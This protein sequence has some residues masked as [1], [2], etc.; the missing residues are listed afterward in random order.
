MK[1]EA[2]DFIYIKPGVPHEVYNIGDDSSIAFVARSTADEWDKIIRLSVPG[3]ARCPTAPRSLS[4]IAM[5]PLRGGMAIPNFANVMPKIIYTWDD[6]D[7]LTR[8]LSEQLR[9]QP[10]DAV[11]AITRG[12]MIRAASS[13]KC[14]T[15]GMS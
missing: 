1:N 10:I 4:G 7:A 11:M 5:P 6:I 8:Q 2:G 15:S 13:A 3:T 14:S 12:G 9:G